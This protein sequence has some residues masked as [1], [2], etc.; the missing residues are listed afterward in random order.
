MSGLN[1]REKSLVA[2][3]AA[4]ASNCV[5]C[6]EFHI[7]AARRAGL[8]DIEISQAIEIADTVRQVPARSVLE[9]AL[10]RIDTSP[11]GGPDTATRGCGCSESRRT[12]EIGGV[13]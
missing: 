6:V 9:T 8:G 5:P 2:L 10:A 13:S 7:P 4:L 12:P 11:E 1:N 3:G